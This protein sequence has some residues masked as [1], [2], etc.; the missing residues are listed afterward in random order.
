MLT[1]VNRVEIVNVRSIEHL[2]VEFDPAGVTAVV[3]PT[4]AGKST[5][6]AALTWVMYGEYRDGGLVQADMRRLGAESEDC[7]VI[8]DLALNG[9]TVQVRRALRRAKRKGAVIEQASAQV[10]IAGVEQENITPTTATRLIESMTGLTARSFAGAFYLPQNQLHLMAEGS[11][12]EIAQLIEDQTGMARLQKAI[13]EAAA[14][15]RDSVKAAER[16]DGSLDEVASATAAHDAADAA[17]R[18]ADEVSDTA[19]DNSR[20]AADEAHDAQRRADALVDAERAAKT[21]ANSAAEAR[22]R[23]AAAAETYDEARAAAAAASGE[24]PSDMQAA[25]QAVTARAESAEVVAARV[26]SAVNDVDTATAILTRAEDEHSAASAALAAISATDDPAVAYSTADDADAQTERAATERARLRTEHDRLS[27]TLE[28]LNDAGD[29]AACPTCRSPLAAGVAGLVAELTTEMGQ[30]IEKGISAA[31][32]EKSARARKAAAQDA[33][34][35]AEHAAAKA[36]EARERTSR[37]DDSLSAARTQLADACRAAAACA[38]DTSNNLN[39]VGSCHDRLAALGREVVEARDT[40]SLLKAVITAAERAAAAR[41]SEA[42]ALDAADRAQA[43]DSEEVTIARELSA[44]ARATAAE[45][46]STAA[47]AQT[48][49][50]VAR[51]SEQGAARG[52]ADA[53]DRWTA[54]QEAYVVAENDRAAHDVLRALRGDLLTEYTAVISESATD[55]LDQIGSDHIAFTITEEFVPTVTRL[56]GAVLPTRTLSGGEKARA[57]LAMRL[58]ISTLLTGGGAPAMLF[59]DEIT[60]ALDEES[61]QA[62]IGVLR[63]LGVRLVLVSHTQEAQ[64]IATR[65]VRLDKQDNRTSAAG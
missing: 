64:D 60:A 29:A 42:Q 33:A 11:P 55:V 40:L 52:F 50:R 47:A 37:A 3:G 45:L 46:S 57:A 2:V 43:P 1:S 49:A 39:P 48:T 51:A 15:A 7:V 5:I 56:D 17:A 32:A 22:G 24:D 63:E 65:V 34:R 14:T 12:T 59:A 9:D 23:A 13:T 36:R 16:L 53:A 38:G 6:L 35:A 27:R 25:V 28:T 26:R 44:R 20:H 21:A 41:A 10:W 30:V 4:G 31:T 54:K 8:A 18:D 62:V 19:I 61:R 58:G